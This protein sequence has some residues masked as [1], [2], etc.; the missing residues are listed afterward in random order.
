MSEDETASVID[1]FDDSR[2]RYIEGSTLGEGWVGKVNALYSATKEARGSKILFL[3]ADI[4]LL[5]NDSLAQLLGKHQEQGDGTIISG[6]PGQGGNGL[7]LVSLLSFFVYTGSPWLLA[8]LLPFPFL[9]I[10]N[11]QVWMIDRSSY[12]K[13][14]P[15]LH[16]K[17]EI[18]DDVKIG[19]FMKSKNVPTTFLPLQ[20]LLKVNMY[21][22]LGEAI[23]GF[24]KN[25]YLLLSGNPIG[26]LVLWTVLL[27]TLV[28]SPFLSLYFLIAIFGLKIV[29]DRLG[30]LP[31]WVS[32]L[33]PASMLAGSLI[34]LYSA[35][36]HW[37]GKVT[38]KN[39]PL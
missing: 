1:S 16:V 13:H 27:I 10:L 30:R 36:L 24:S 28:L 11:G 9:T 22:D 18:L 34:Q 7:L 19:R 21:K 39:R 6:L 29:T 2:I 20:K 37:R 4:E 26:F 38:W 32:V 3:D 8:K 17:H 5:K 35:I 12:E 25:A 23:L 15:H 14:Q 31:L 33:A